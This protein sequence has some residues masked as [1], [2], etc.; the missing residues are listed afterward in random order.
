MSSHLRLRLAT[1]HDQPQIVALIDSIFR[2]Y[3]AEV[4]LEGAE[5]DLLDI[6]LNY[7]SRGGVFWVLEQVELDGQAQIVG[8]HSAIPLEEPRKC[9]FKRLYV[10]EHLRGTP[11]TRKLMQVAI[12]WAKAREYEQVQFWSDTRFGRA[13]RFFAKFGFRQTGEIRHMKDSTEPYSEYS[14]VLD[15]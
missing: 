14:F 10:A 11:W 2:E 12:D 6:Q 8:S 7:V 4:C 5:A 3:D 15:L 9:T 1:E 13:H